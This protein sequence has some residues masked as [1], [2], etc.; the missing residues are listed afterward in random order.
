ML[1]IVEYSGDKESLVNLVEQLQ[2]FLIKIDPLK[3]LQRSSSYGEIYVNDLLEKIHANEGVIYIAKID[4][5]NMGMIAGVIETQT[6]VDK[7]GHIKSKVGN[8]I[9]LVVS[10]EYRGKHVGSAL[11]NTIE[12]YFRLKRCDTAWVEVFVPNKSAHDF[13]KKSNYQDRM[14]GMIKNL[15]V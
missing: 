2:D 15:S 8:I 14:L 12:E 6:K 10:E 1:K 7:V 4:E 5:V 3:R 11:M 13:Y 9:E